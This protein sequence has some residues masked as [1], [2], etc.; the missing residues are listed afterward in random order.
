MGELLQPGGVEALE[1]LGLRNCIDAIDGIDNVGYVVIKQDEMVV[2]PYPAN[3]KPNAGRSFHHGRFVMNLRRKAYSQT[4][5]VTCVAATAVELINHPVTSRNIGVMVKPPSSTVGHNS[6]DTNKEFQVFAPLTVA[7]DGCFSKFRKELIDRPVLTTSHFV[8]LILED[9][10]LPYANHGHVVMAQPSIVLL[11]QIGTHETRVLVDIPGKLPSISNG[12]M[13]D[14]MEKTVAPQLPQTVRPSFM[15]AVLK[16]GFRSMPN[17]WLPPTMNNQEGV[18]LVG[19]SS[20]MRHPIT[21]AGMTVAL[22][23]VVHLRNTLRS[24]PN[25][26]NTFLVTTNVK[27]IH[28][29]RKRLSSVLNILANALYALCSPGSNE[30]MSELQNAVFAY[31]RLG[32]RC[33]TTPTGMLGG[34]IREPWT[35]V[36]HFF[37]VALYGSFL[38]LTQKASIVTFPWRVIEC[39]LV[40]HCACQVILPLILVELF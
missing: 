3:K 20:N 26:T 14:Y 33:V 22:W 30:A 35:L 12:D 9:C 40:L 23:D 27:R 16:G 24:T 13:K 31:F 11:Y 15:K 32:G 29:T 5:N 2:L 10:V 18:V 8:G 1:L 19:D 39:I 17:S 34:I 7:C 37:A 25:L 36:G 6:S 28:W 21:G 4:Q 38:I